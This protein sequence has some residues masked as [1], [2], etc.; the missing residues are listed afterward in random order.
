MNVHYT[1]S[2]YANSNIQTITIYKF[3][4]EKGVLHLTNKPPR[5]KNKILYSRSY[6][7]EFY[8]PPPPPIIEKHISTPPRTSTPPRKSSDYVALVADVANQ[9]GLSAAL[10]HAVIKVESNYNPKALSP[11]GAKGLMQLMPAT[12][13]R[14]GVTNRADPVANVQAGAK[15]LRDLSNMF[16]HD[17]SLVLAA[18]NAGENAVKRYGNKIPPY[19]ETQNYVQKVKTLYHQFSQA[20]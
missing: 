15:Y 6:V 8:Q 2:V 3:L 12:A 17:L 9:T 7:V 16:N 20:M 1:P 19:R 5:K 13:K 14:Y 4:D 10:L 11:K 18:Y